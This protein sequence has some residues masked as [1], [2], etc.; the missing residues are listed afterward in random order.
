MF[1]A[2]HLARYRFASRL[3]QGKRVLDAGT[4]HGYGAVFLLHG[5]AA[6]V[7]AVDIAADVIEDAR[8]EFGASG[9]DFA[10]D[11]CQTFAKSRGP[12]DLVVN[13]ENIEHVPK[14]R[15]LL[16]AVTG[17]LASGGTFLT[18]SPDRLATPPFIN[19]KPANPFH[20][21]EWTLEEFESLMREYFNE[22]VMHVQ[23][24]SHAYNRRVIGVTSLNKYITLAN[25]IPRLLN[26]LLKRTGNGSLYGTLADL[27]SP[28]IDDFP[29]VSPAMGALVG[30]PWVVIAECRGPRGRE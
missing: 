17:I 22:V 29:I 10:V 2:D 11:D 5:G 26:S 16:K 21:N 18:S 25:P 3:A 12:F 8:R 13:F 14:P 30:T 24:R 6:S 23:V 1:C 4:G 27:S 19:G 15:D 7:R 9:I 20:V 28:S